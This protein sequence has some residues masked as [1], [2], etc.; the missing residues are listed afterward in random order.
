[1]SNYL[2]DQKPRQLAEGLTGHYIHGH[3]MTMGVVEIKAGSQLAQHQ[4]PHEQITYI[5]EGELDMIIGGEQHT[6]R[7]GMC[8]VIPSNTLHGATA[9]TDCKVLDVF[10]P[11]REDY[12]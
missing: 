7:A 12:V 1:M 4:H 11:V 9:H 3:S 5:L 8:F 10:T 2:K 6:L